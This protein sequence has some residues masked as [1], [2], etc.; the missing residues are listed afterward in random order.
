MAIYHLSAQVISRSKGQS[1]VA[2]AAYRS[3]E[4]LIDERTG[5]TKFYKREVQPETMI[6]APSNSPEWVQDRQQLWNEV[7]KSETRKNSQVAREINIALPRELSDSEQTKLIRGYVQKEF[8]DQGMIADVAIHRD[9]KENP[10]AHVMLTTREISKEGFT[11]KNRDWNKKEWLME[12]REQWANQANQALERQGIQE[13]ITHESHQTR[14]LIIFPTVHLGHVAHEMEHRGIQTNRGNINRDVQKYNGLVVNL[15]KYREEKQA[16]EQEQTRQQ[17]Q[18]QK[19]ETFYTAAELVD[20]QEASKIVKSEP[21]QENLNKRREELDIGH[22]DANRND[23]NLF[24]VDAKFKEVS[25]Y[26]RQIQW[27][28]NQIEESQEKINQINWL[29][30]L[31]RKENR[32]TK[33]RAE[34]TMAESQVQIQS[35]KEKLAF[36]GKIFGFSTEQEFTHVRSHHETYRSVLLEENKN[37]RQQIFYERETLEK[38]ETAHSN[39]LVRQVA[40]WYPEYPEMRYITIETANNLMGLKQKNNKVIP[41][42][43]IENMLN[44]Q[45]QE[46]QR[47][48]EEISRVDRTQLRLQSAEDSLNHYEKHQ[49]VVEK[50]ENNPFLKGKMRVSKSTRQEYNGAISTRDSHKES[51]EREGVS[52]KMDLKKQQ[53]TLEKMEAKIPEFKKQIQSKERGLDLL[54]SIIKGIGQA[55][56]REERETKKQRKKQ[57]YRGQKE[58]ELDY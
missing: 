30:P 2:S 39:A 28:Q 35:H 9:D 32:L 25:D 19:K 57:L 4:R 37:I 43:H 6:L 47:L 44:H 50:Y 55:Q 7:E 29:N 12:W 42:E 10:H 40:S 26:Y 33:E 27:A 58:H 54:D 17:E 16:L 3:G 41:I 21:T 13:R 56:T 22:K 38:A 34:Q 48:Q 1:A 5:E 18:K 20:L 8:V 24:L 36:L 53:G 51:M 49:E 52:G 31:K 11:V 15:Q 23:Q 14:N 46:I 45:K